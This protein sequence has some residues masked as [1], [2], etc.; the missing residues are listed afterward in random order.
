MSV[1][2]LYCLQRTHWELTDS[3]FHASLA[4][5]DFNGMVFFPY[6]LFFFFKQTHVEKKPKTTNHKAK[7]FTW[8]KKFEIKQTKLRNDNYS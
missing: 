8:L 3:I 1:L 4:G 2:H 6:S 7:L 5:E